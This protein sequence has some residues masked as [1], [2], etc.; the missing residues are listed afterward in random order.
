V[1]ELLQYDA[2]PEKLGQA[3]ER[4]LN[5][6]GQAVSVMRAYADIH[7]SLR[8]NASE[9][10]ALAIQGLLQRPVGHAA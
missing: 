4:F 1:P 2:V 3:V 9:Q 10:A 5:Y 6:P 7:A 8:C